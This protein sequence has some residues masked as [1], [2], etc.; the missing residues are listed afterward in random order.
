MRVSL[1]RDEVCDIVIAHLQK[2]GVMPNGKV[3][4]AKRIAK[5]D[6]SEGGGVSPAY[7]TSP[8]WGDW[9]AVTIDWPSKG[10]GT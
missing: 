5:L 8:E 1:T 4:Y 2:E 9:I 7:L 3:T 10:N 6:E